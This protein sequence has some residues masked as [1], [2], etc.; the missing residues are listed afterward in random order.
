MFEV[1]WNGLKCGIVFL[2]G[3]VSRNIFVDKRNCKF[4]G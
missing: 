1:L 3:V 4:L 2:A